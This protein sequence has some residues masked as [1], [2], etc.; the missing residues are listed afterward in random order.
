LA[1]LCTTRFTR[2]QFAVHAELQFTKKEDVTL[3][4][5]LEQVSKFILADSAAASVSIAKMKG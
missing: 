2:N 4:S 5:V 3:D 1:R